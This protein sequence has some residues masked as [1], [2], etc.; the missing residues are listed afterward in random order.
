VGDELA[1]AV[2]GAGVQATGAV[3]LALQTDTDVLNGT[4]EDR[5]GDTGK[6]ARGVVLAV[7]E[8]PG[9]LVALLEPAAGVVEGAELD[10]DAGADSDERCDGALVEGQGAFVFVD[11]SCGVDGTRVLGGGLEADLDNIEWLAC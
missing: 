4:G 3:R 1:H 11:G 5:V 6:G 7:G 8:G 10:R 2:N 9:G